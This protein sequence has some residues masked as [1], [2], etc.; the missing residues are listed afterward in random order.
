[1]IAVEKGYFKEA[2]V[3]VEVSEL[4][5]AANARAID[6]LLAAVNINPALP[7]SWRWRRWQRLR[8]HRLPCGCCPAAA[9]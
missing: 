1:M 4:D 6:S 5:S 9:W 8:N 2:G 3:K 7:A